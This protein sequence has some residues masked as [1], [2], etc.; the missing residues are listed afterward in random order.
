L[1]GPLCYRPSQDQ[2]EQVHR[3]LDLSPSSKR[4]RL[5]RR[6]CESIF[7]PRAAP[8]NNPTDTE[9]TPAHPPVDS[10]T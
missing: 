6:P 8:P 1:E 5:V 3:A 7:A 4:S 2:P 10:Y 9:S